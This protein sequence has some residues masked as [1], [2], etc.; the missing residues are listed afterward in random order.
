[1]MF[2]ACLGCQFRTIHCHE[3]CA[4]HKAE[5]EARKKEAEAERQNMSICSY[6]ADKHAQAEHNKK[7]HHKI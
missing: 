4:L 7:M 1:M 5:V 6:Y 2:K 3:T